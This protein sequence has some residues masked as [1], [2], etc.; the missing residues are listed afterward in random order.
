MVL[1][2]LSE[3]MVDTNKE[4]FAEFTTY[5]IENAAAEDSQL[6]TDV[7]VNAD[8]EE[9]SGMIFD[10]LTSTSG[11]MEDNLLIAAV[12]EEMVYEDFT[13]IES[14]DS[15]IKSHVFETVVI[16]VQEIEEEKS[17]VEYTE[18]A[19]AKAERQAEKQ[20]AKLEKQ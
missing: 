18:K 10:E 6:I 2:T 14:L 7:L 9:L 16:A 3:A 4:Q 12:F 13:I 11:T 19:I 17:F 5:A 1:A 8:N 20:E 15:D